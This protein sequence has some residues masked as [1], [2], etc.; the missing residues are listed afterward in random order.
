M[1]TCI[2]VSHLVLSSLG[3][4]LSARFIINPITL[5]VVVRFIHLVSPKLKLAKMHKMIPNRMFGRVLAND[6]GAAGRPG[7]LSCLHRAWICM[8]RSPLSPVG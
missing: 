8:A 3:L 7:C 2:P 4:F 6:L 5:L 1:Y